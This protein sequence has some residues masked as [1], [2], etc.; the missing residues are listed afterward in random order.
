MQF[1][2]NWLND[3]IEI[4]D[5]IKDPSVLAK[6]LTETGLEVE[7]IQDL[8]SQLQG[9]VVGELKSVV[10]HP[11]ADRL[12]LCK[13]ETGTQELSIV[14]G[15]KNQ[16]QGD[17]VAVALV[18]STLPQGLKIKEASIRGEKSY[19]MLASAEELGLEKS[20]EGILI[21]PSEAVPGTAL[22]QFFGKHD[23]LIEV[24]VTPNRAD[25]LSH[26]GL[27]R[28]IS[29]LFER[30]WKQKKESLSTNK[31]LS[32]KSHIS[33]KLKD[34]KNCSRYTGR[35]L[36]GV[37]VKDSPSWLK[38][39]LQ[40]M[41]MNSINNIVDATNYI[42][43]EQGQ[44]LHAFDLDK[45]T[46]ITIDN[47]KKGEAFLALDDKELTLT[48]EELTIRD[49]KN[50]LALAGVIG[51]KNSAISNKTQNIF[52]ES[53][54]FTPET[55][56][57]TSRRFGLQTDSSHQFSR[58]VDSERVKE[59]LDQACALIQKVAGGQISHDC[60]DECSKSFQTQKIQISIEEIAERLEIPITASEFKKIMKRLQCEVS[61]EKNEFKV[62][63]PSFR[64]DLSIKED[65]IEEVARLQGYNQ[66]PIKPVH[67]VTKLSPS[68][69]FFSYVNSSKELFQRHGWHETLHYSF[70]DPEFY[71]EFLKEKNIW[72]QNGLVSDNSFSI[73]NPI[74]SQLS[75]MK[76]L[77]LPDLLK[78]TINN[79]RKNNKDGRIFE[80]S[81]VFHKIK[82]TYTQETH[83]SFAIWGTPLQFW[84]LKQIPNNIFQ[85]KS[86]MEFLMEKLRYKNWE[87]KPLNPT[88]SF[89]HPKQ[90]LAL[91]IQ[92]QPL[93]LIGGLHP[94]MK[95][96]YKIPV[97]VTLGE[98]HLENLW[99]CKRHLPKY[100]Q[101]SD[102]LT[103]ER[104]L[105]FVLPPQV[106]VG[107]IQTTIKKTLGEVCTQVTLFD[108][109]E[110][111][112]KRSVSFRMFLTPKETSW[113]DQDLKQ[114]Q[115][116]VIDAVTQK[117]PVQL[118]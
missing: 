63:P 1:S 115:D 37:Q 65:L 56:R 28:E 26:M 95:E 53:A 103:V 118:T 16:K 43:M 81:P 33:V 2:F 10:P 8:K 36:T 113:T 72:K 39:R 66:I 20:S 44:P 114:F 31:S 14:C 27:A 93:G 86:A 19:G 23:I 64:T 106:S 107:D 35:I 24:N 83:L 4:K 100:Q 32:V 3:F 108:I 51:G 60:Y 48:G 89:L 116:K 73:S 71:T 79:F 76:P 75:L 80:I 112:D 78:T 55:V 67:P 117:F 101:L 99:K 85:I 68:Q 25:C 61:Q 9:V 88:L 22:S 91:Y 97:D 96:K 46:S 110:K 52:V 82:E 59:A 111:E 11:N 5:F 49:G 54:H 12:T 40:L 41:G 21:L 109:Y 58:G 69:P 34:K 7:S 38:Q 50:I 47:S 102:H 87:W 30:P 45:L 62:I 13:V 94:H 29:C 84:S 104:D 90:S 92:N 6:A 70:S 15:A 98:F 18:G 105:S 74:S 17:K 42:L 57:K 77:L